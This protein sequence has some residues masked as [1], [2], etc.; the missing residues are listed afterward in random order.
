ML[1]LPNPAAE[2]SNPCS[3]NSASALPLEQDDIESELYDLLMD[4]ESDLYD[5]EP[6]PFEPFVDDTIRPNCSR[7]SASSQDVH[8]LGSVIFP[9]WREKVK[10]IDIDQHSYSSAL[11]STSISISSSSYADT[12][13]VQVQHTTP[14]HADLIPLPHQTLPNLRNA[15][16]S[17]RQLLNGMNDTSVQ[18][19][20]Q[21]VQEID[22]DNGTRQA[23]TTCSQFD[24]DMRL[25]QQTPPTPTPTT[26]PQQQLTLHSSRPPLLSNPKI[27]YNDIKA[28][29]RKKR[30]RHVPPSPSSAITKKPK[31]TK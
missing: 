23:M 30:A 1:M 5:L 11:D 16:P 29:R 4:I 26:L 31:Q 17:F 19:R 15:S 14:T 3:T 6:L 24:Q 12:P 7:E 8:K 27:S 2:S 9:A 13:A 25:Q 21:P 10:T 20:S 18:S 28:A 22:F